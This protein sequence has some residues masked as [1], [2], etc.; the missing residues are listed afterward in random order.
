MDQQNEQIKELTAA[1]ENLVVHR[2][3]L[4]K[5]LVKLSKRGTAPKVSKDFIAVQSTIETIERA[6][7]HERHL[8]SGKP[9]PFLWPHV[10]SG[11]ED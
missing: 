3:R 2:R 4:A 1:R 5:E 9:G 10:V 11:Y 6:I 8:E 7:A